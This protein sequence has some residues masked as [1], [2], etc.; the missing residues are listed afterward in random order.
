M[1]LG[2]GL[3]LGVGLGLG[4]GLGAG[5]GVGLGLG[6]TYLSTESVVLLQ[7]DGGHLPLTPGLTVAL[8]GSACSATS[9]R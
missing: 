2:L 9:A 7:N 5:V 1:G 6:L 4:L 3:G 8:L